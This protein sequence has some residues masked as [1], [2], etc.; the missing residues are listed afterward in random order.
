ML[1][2][3]CD[4]SPFV[5]LSK[6]DQFGLLR[7]VYDSVY[8][9]TAVWRE[10]A[11]GG[12]GLVES[13]NLKSAV[14]D[15]SIRVE[16]PSNLEVQAA[17]FPKELGRGEVEAIVLA[18]ELKAVVVTDDGL[19]RSV[20]VSRGLEVTGTVGVLIRA[21]RHQHL[22]AVKPLLERLKQNTNFRMSDSFYEE[23]LRSAGE[24]A[25]TDN[26]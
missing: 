3:V 7:L 6:L 22:L 10:V 15:G 1:A 18:C 25:R 24:S 4:S 16:T 11:I 20:A 19:G 23:A 5:Y 9:P 26:S 14:A 21:K 13:V 8:V 2:V 17:G 12:E